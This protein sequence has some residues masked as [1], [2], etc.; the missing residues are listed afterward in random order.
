MGIPAKSLELLLPAGSFDSAIAAIEG[1]ANALYFGFT[2]FS[3]RKQARNLDRLEYRR[4]LR[5]AR[6][7]GVR[8]FVTVNT[9]IFDREL[10]SVSELLAFLGR[11]PPDSIIVQDWGLARLIRDRYPGLAIH[12]STQT[13]IQGADA[14][15][16]AA[17]LGAVRVV[18]PRETS[19][20]AMRRIKTAFP[21]MEF[22]VFVH[23]AL[24][25]SFSGLCL[26]SGML[27]GRSG[28]RGEC[29][30]VCRSYYDAETESG[31]PSGEGYW[32]SCRDLCLVER[33]EAL[34]QAGMSSIKVEG[35]MKSPEYGYAVARLYRAALDGLPREEIAARLEAARTT[36]AREYTEGW[37]VERGGAR[38]I[39]PQFPGHRGALAGRVA[40]SGRGRA[41][42]ELASSLGLRDG[43]LVFEGEGATRPVQFAVADLRDHRT[44]RP[45]TVARP[46]DLVELACPGV[47]RPGSEARRISDRRQ[48]RRAESAEEYPPALSEIPLALSLVRGPEGSRFAAEIALPSF[49]GAAGRGRAAAIEPGEAFEAQAA[50]SP[51][52]FMKAL[53]TFSQSG[54][55]DFRLVPVG[56]LSAVADLFV[57]P[58]VVKREK[59][60]IYAAARSL[61]E[62]EHGAYAAASVAASFGKA[63]ERAASIAHREALAASDIPP[64]ACLVFPYD[65]LPSGM[66]FATP[67]LL[68]ERA[69]LPRWGDR[70]WLPL[71]PLVADLPAYEGLVEDRVRSELEA[72]N[73]IALGLGGLH[74]V[75]LAR[76]LRAA[77]P[78]HDAE[79]DGR[80]AFFIDIH[81]YIANRLALAVFS[82]LV[83]GAIF[84]YSYLEAEPQ[85]AIADLPP[86]PPVAPLGDA[87]SPAR[88]FEPPLF[89]SLGCLRKHHASNGRCPA[90]CDRR[91]SARLADRDREYMAISE[92]CVSM[93][94]RLPA[95]G[96][97][98]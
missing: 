82:S 75:A 16:L 43:L 94:F 17:E 1:G 79:A 87:G 36:F 47:P 88:R 49:T 44:G 70:S 63:L 13:A 7:K 32:F 77:A 96:R 76:R 81:F 68:R 38:L 14:A 53:A 83:P 71:M 22:E 34:A 61:V 30:Q 6:E 28:N 95:K 54:E 51:G 64:R 78:T 31:G 89:L 46:G 60:R 35:R 15:R 8:L 62:A 11:F 67:R 65:G 84:A 37:L 12:A 25:Y 21:E 85:Q 50:K 59:N 90:D 80:L 56:D 29:A 55:A 41:V 9:V 57:P 48:D 10:E 58:S 91:W 27:L 69:A 26:A 23:G 73:R 18:L 19:L 97:R 66:P 86:L 24:C 92:D 93:L 33:L 72:G 42:L 3:A 4:L 45:L 39:D 20:D 40:A 2:D 98:P 5:Y 74:H 52:G